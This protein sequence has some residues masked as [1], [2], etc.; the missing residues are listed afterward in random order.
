MKQNNLQGVNMYTFL[1]LMKHD[2]IWMNERILFISY[3]KRL[4]KMYKHGFENGKTVSVKAHASV[5]VILS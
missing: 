1:L 2:I 4:E 3:R 5:K